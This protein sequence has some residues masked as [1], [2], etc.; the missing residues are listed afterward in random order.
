MLRNLVVNNC[1]TKNIWKNH[2]AND[3]HNHKNP[4]SVAGHIVVVQMR[5]EAFM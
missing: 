1:T 3:R 4:E 2:V 5:H